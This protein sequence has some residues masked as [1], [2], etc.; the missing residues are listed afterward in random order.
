MSPPTDIKIAK[1]QNSQNDLKWIF[2]LLGSHFC[3]FLLSILIS[4]NI[5][6]LSM[7]IFL[8]L[9]F[10]VVQSIALKLEIFKWI[11]LSLPF[12]TRE[13]LVETGSVWRCRS[14]ACYSPI[15]DSRNIQGTLL[16]R[17]TRAVCFSRSTIISWIMN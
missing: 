2:L 1:K 3:Y 6:K 15:W 10:L 17:I 7:T 8:H 5:L 13:S 12:W 11:F 14:E 4:D 16:P 9:L